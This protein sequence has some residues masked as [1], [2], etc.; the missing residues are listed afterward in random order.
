MINIKDNFIM[1]KDKT[2][3]NFVEDFST[4]TVFSST[5]SM[6]SRES[7]YRSENESSDIISESEGSNSI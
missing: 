5:E 3:R 1:L 2:G 4:T 7:D 6:T